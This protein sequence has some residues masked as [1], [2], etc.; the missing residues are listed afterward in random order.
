MINDVE[1]DVSE[2]ISHLKEYDIDGMPWSQKDKCVG[3][4][5]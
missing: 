5:A 4:F 3:M 2:H 1:K